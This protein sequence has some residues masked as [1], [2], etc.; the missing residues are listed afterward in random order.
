MGRIVVRDMLFHTQ[1]APHSLEGRQRYYKSFPREWNSYSPVS[2]THTEGPKNPTHISPERPDESPRK[3]LSFHYY[4]S[5][6]R[7]WYS[8]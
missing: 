8:H 7:E 2:G 1:M 5:F 4:K 6:P 3:T